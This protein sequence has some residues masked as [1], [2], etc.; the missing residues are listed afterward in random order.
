MLASGRLGLLSAAFATLVLVALF[1]ASDGSIT[2]ASPGG[3]LNPGFEDGQLGG[4]PVDWDVVQPVPDAVV[5]V[6]QE[7]PA[8][9]T[10][11]ADQNITVTPFIGELMQR[12]GSPKQLNQK[13]VRGENIA[14]QTFI[15]DQPTLKFAFRI[16]SWEHR[17][18]DIF[19]FDLTDG[20][21]SVGTLAPITVV[22]PD[23][24]TRSC[25][26]LP[27]QF[28][29]DVGKK[30]GQF[31][32]SG[33]KVA[34]IQ[35]VPTGIPLTLTY[36]TGGTKN[37]SFATWTYWDN[38]NTPPVAKFIFAP[39]DPLE[40]DVVQ[41]VDGSF[42]P[43][44]GDSIVSWEWNIDGEVFTSQNPF[45]IFP[46]E[47]A[48]SASLTVTDTDG[49]SATVST[50]GTATDGT[51]VPPLVVGNA[52]PLVNALNVEA[53]ADE[54]VTVIGRFLDPGW[55]DVHSAAWSLE[56]LEGD[57][58][59]VEGFDDDADGS[60][61]EDPVDGVDNDGDCVGDPPAEL[62]GLCSISGGIDE[63]PTLFEENDPLVSSGLVPGFVTPSSDLIGTLT[64]EDGDGGVGSDS[65]SV[66]IVPDDSTRHEPN[67]AISDAPVLNT[68]SVNLSWVGSD[69]DIDLYEVRLADGSTLAVDAQLLVTLSN[70]PQDYDVAILSQPPEEAAAGF[71]RIGFSR[72]GFSR[73][74]F[75][76]IGFSRI[77]SSV[78][79]FS[80]IGFS[81]IGF[82]RIGFS[83][84]GLSTFNESGAGWADLGFSRIGFSRIGFSRIGFSRIGEVTPTDISLEE[85]GLGSIGGDGVQVV[86]FSANRGLDDEVAWAQSS[87]DGTKFYVAVFGHN[88]AFSTSQPY[89][90][91]LEVIEA[92]DLEFELGA[93]C[94]GSPLVGPEESTS[95]V[96][97]L[98]DYDDAS[99]TEVNEPAKTQLVTQRERF[100]AIY[101]QAAWDSMLAD[102][103]DLAQHDGVQGD[104][105]SVPS[106][107]YD[108]WDINQC[109]IEAAN[110]VAAEIRSI[111]QARL[112]GIDNDGDGLFAE[113]PVDGIDNDSDGLT[114]ED[115][116]DGIDNDGDGS[117]DE[118]PVDGIDNDS[119]GLIDEDPT[120]NIVLAGNDQIIPFRRVQDDTIIGNEQNYLLDSFQQPGSP[121]FI[122][123]LLGN[124]LTDHYFADE[125]GDAWQG[126]ELY[127]PDRPIGRL[128]ETPEEISAAAQAY[129]L[130]D[131]VLEPET[132]FV[133]GYDFFIDG[134]EEIA[135]NLD[136]GLSGTVDRLINDTWTSDDLRCSFLGQGAA[137]EC[138][139]RDLSSPNAHYTHYAALSANGFVTEDFGDFLGSDEVAAA[140]GG[141][142]ALEGGVVFSMGCHAGFNS[143]D[144][145]TAA[146]DE[147][148]GIDPALDFV[149]AMAI[150]RAVYLASTAYA[151]GD[152]EGT[153]GTER[154]LGIFA[155]QLLQGSVTVG[156][157]HV[158][159]VQ[160]HLNSLGI[161]TVYD[162]KSAIAL[163]L[164]GLPMYR[165]DPAVT[166]AVASITIE[167]LAVEETGPTFELTTV[168]AAATEP[169]RTVTTAHS[170][171]L[172][173]TV[174]G[175]YYTLEGDFQAT[176][177]RPIEPIA[178]SELDE[179]H[180]YA[181]GPPPVRGVLVKGGTFTDILGWDP[182]N[183][184][185]TFEYEIDVAEPQDCLSGFWPSELATVNSIEVETLVAFAGQFQCTD[186]GPPVTGVQRLGESLTLELLRC[187]ASSDTDPPVVNSIDLRSIDDTTVEVTVDASDPGGI[188]R[189]VV[190]RIGVGVMVSTELSLSGPLP[191]DGSFILIVADVGPDDA[192]TIQVADGSCNTASATGK[193]AGGV[194][195][196]SVDAGPDQAYAPGVP[197]SFVTTVFGCSDLTEPVSFVW[198]FGDGESETGI[199]APSELATVDVTV[200]AFG[201]CAF[202][203]EHTYSSS[204]P[205]APTATVKVTDAAGGVGVDD[206]LLRRCGDPAGDVAAS[207]DPTLDLTNADL[208]DCSVSNTS[209]TMSIGIRVAGEISD[210]F[211]YR[212]RL[213]IG[214]FEVDPDTG[215]KVLVSPEPD[216]IADRNLQFDAGK[217][218][219]LSSL[220]VIPILGGD[221]TVVGLEYTFSLA[222]ISK[223]VGDL[224]RWS[225]ETQAGVKATGETGKVDHMPDSGLFGVVLR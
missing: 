68:D 156:D 168:D 215:E 167:P 138:E 50:G 222:D 5:V 36:S 81:R 140:E 66:T 103:I 14:F 165:I 100:I 220:Q 187:S 54:E 164:W 133:S 17:N 34:E 141:S 224:V 58:V 40:G 152:D 177:G 77:D 162:E 176:P 18:L 51:P 24:S 207:N 71:S 157:A 45:F 184:R 10:T 1:S 144:G 13:Q 21:T 178:V 223:G 112:D 22:M 56:T 154:I 126:R 16:F 197:V 217:V 166:P 136:A 160:L 19:R 151:Y 175:D 115:P 159:S 174:D 169:T 39:D 143:P 72:I 83:R 64:V 11:Y 194:S 113:D 199:L 145:L 76:R 196:V 53:L 29:I 221:D 49:A 47:G 62:P 57:P 155:E 116:V 110:A 171:E 78:L 131:G 122:S 104:I 183:A 98:H 137:P 44:P 190:L 32:D 135:D 95:S 114:D 41:F 206:V 90:L 26:S 225:A 67:D 25:D 63:D 42:D 146:P 87:Q 132:G 142:P 186:P 149:Q 124:T 198:Q 111:I 117:T 127:V 212:V 189:I 193:G 37:E 123:I 180:V 85:L 201:D 75:S 2:L 69:G 213:D 86:D 172:V 119:D 205:P 129:L 158:K 125:V 200:D 93:L 105:I 73:I 216:G 88:G 109:S 43:D 182:R 27:C 139:A 7:G 192:L 28:S 128:G 31:L 214:T 99:T 74:G 15:A 97:V 46:D 35:D 153:G 130:S 3:L 89:S 203:V 55:E 134:T 52:D 208:V 210:N 91:G 179:R 82:S 150:Q 202:G 48:F 121:L 118:D 80:R 8:D 61:D 4:F 96:V 147:G 59:P 170:L 6:D 9:S 188:A 12:T 163:T 120:E 94:T 84:I 106:D 107:I 204:A 211:K 38:V 108:D 185:P 70:L 20:V 195:L 219:G 148:L 30:K 60:I 102:L 65:F 33:W 101:G 173:E 79:G 161:M 209:T 218:T 191:T 92:P 181:T 23:G